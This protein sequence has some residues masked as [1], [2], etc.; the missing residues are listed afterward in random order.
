MKEKSYQS[1]TNA[2]KIKF[3]E[4]NKFNSKVGISSDFNFDRYIGAPLHG[5]LPFRKTLLQ[6]EVA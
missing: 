2:L 6:K 1:I 3:H 5:G 4:I